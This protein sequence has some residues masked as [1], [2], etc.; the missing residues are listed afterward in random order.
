MSDTAIRVGN[1]G[2]IVVP[3]T[4]RENH[5]WVEGTVLI[6][7]DTP[8]GLLLMSEDEALRQVREQTG[9]RSLVQELM[10]ERRAAALIEDKETEA[11]AG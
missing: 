5:A 6:A 3:V 4:V 9:G 1:K 7:V 10:D 2:R 11:Y 8:S